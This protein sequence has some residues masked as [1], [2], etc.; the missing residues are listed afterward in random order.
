MASKEFD[1]AV[2][3]DQ[4]EQLTTAETSEPSKS[5]A[6]DSTVQPLA[7]NE[8]RTETTPELSVDTTTKL[9]IEKDSPTVPDVPDSVTASLREEL[10]AMD[11]IKTIHTS[12]DLGPTSSSAKTPGSLGQH[13]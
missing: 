4:P 10:V 8:D 9:E 12:G 11:Q 6:V 7:M 1:I 13:S 3:Q 5:V 2:E